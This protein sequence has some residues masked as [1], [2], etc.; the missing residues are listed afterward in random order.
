MH[1]MS[2][3]GRLVRKLLDKGKRD[4]RVDAQLMMRNYVAAVGRRGLVNAP[5]ADLQL[6]A[7]VG[8]ADITIAGETRRKS[9]GSA[10]N[11]L[12]GGF[13]EEVTTSRFH[14]DGIPVDPE[15]EDDAAAP[16]DL[17][18]DYADEEEVDMAPSTSPFTLGTVFA[19]SLA[20]TLSSRA[21]TAKS[22]IGSVR[23]CG[24]GT[25]A[26]MRELMAMDE[27]A[28]PLTVAAQAAPP[29]VP[30]CSFPPPKR[31]KCT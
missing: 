2:R 26:I 15:E 13:F 18:D 19:G 31:M 6:S 11:S 5:I 12:N 24:V 3:Y 20:M 17:E 23:S 7:F 28:P 1:W 29:S 10:N 14:R 16:T 22:L 30:F 4:Q 21:G 27:E 8:F 9:G 25:M